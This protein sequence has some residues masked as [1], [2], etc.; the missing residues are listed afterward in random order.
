MK[1]NATKYNAM[2]YNATKYNAMK[3]NEMTYNAMK[4]NEIEYN[5]I[6]ILMFLGSAKQAPPGLSLSVVCRPVFRRPSVFL[7]SFL[8]FF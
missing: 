1:Y 2:K 5:T 6:M 8:E 7:P 3:Y 4:Y